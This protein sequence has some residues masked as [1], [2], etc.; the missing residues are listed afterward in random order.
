M[1]KKTSKASITDVDVEMSSEVGSAD[2]ARTVRTSKVK[3][4]EEMPDS[5]NPPEGAVEVRR[6][7]SLFLF[8]SLT[9]SR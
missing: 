8:D 4:K 3:A 6:N 1:A 7:C 9:S 2:T 5:D